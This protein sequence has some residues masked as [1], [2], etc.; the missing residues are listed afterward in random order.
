MQSQYLLIRSNKWPERTTRC[1][2]LLKVFASDRAPDEGMEHWDRRSQTGPFFATRSDL[3]PDLTDLDPAIP[4]SVDNPSWTIILDH[5]ELNPYQHLHILLTWQNWI[6][7]T[8]ILDHQELNHYQPLHISLVWHLWIFGTTILNH[9]EL[10]PSQPLHISLNWQNWIFL[11]IIL[12]HQE[13]NHYQHLHIS[14]T[15]HLW[16]F[17]TMILNH[18]ELNP[19]QTLHISLTW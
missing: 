17:L 14:L 11:T 3:D 5:Q 10:N 13:L 7:G 2:P 1:L 6:C 8:I 18:Q 4:R 19:Y 12:D 15:W 9:Q 16:I